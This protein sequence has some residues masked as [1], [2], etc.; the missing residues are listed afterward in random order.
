MDSIMKS[1]ERA[2]YVTR[3]A[4]QKLLSDVEV[5]SVSTAETAASL[6]AGDQFIDL[7]GLEHGVQT[8][9]AVPV[10]M[11]RVLPRKAVHADTWIKILAHLA[12]PRS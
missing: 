6:S 4:I 11:G 5:G 8:A 3:D 1:D 9:G 2:I 12:A 7:E 10:R